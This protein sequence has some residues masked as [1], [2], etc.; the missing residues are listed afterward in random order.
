MALRGRRRATHD[1][2]CDR[3]NSGDVSLRGMVLCTYGEPREPVASEWLWT[4]LGRATGWPR[5]RWPP[6]R[7]LRHTIVPTTL[8]PALLSTAN[9]LYTPC[10]REEARVRQADRAVGKPHLPPRLRRSRL[11][12]LHVAKRSILPYGSRRSG[13]GWRA[14]RVSGRTRRSFALGPCAIIE[15]VRLRLGVPWLG[16]DLGT[17]P[18]EAPSAHPSTTV[19]VRP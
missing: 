2:A 15:A 6:S 4:G 12:A 10:P 14:S 7:S 13:R 1:H 17:P 11:H 18:P 19:G 5:P 16:S 3:A 8:P 9:S